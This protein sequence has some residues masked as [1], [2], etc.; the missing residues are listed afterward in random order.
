VA[1]LLVIEMGF[2]LTYAPS[3][4][5]APAPPPLA[6]GYSNTKELGRLVY[7]EYVYPFEI[8]AGDPAR[9]DRVRHRAHAAPP[10]ADE[11]R[12]PGA[13]DRGAQAGPGED[14]ADACREEK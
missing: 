1:A 3:L 7:T 13:T 9:C 12:G 4:A 8:A 6:A 11:V 2:M 14:S 10:Q 5:D